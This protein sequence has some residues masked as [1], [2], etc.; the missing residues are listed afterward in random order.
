ME[1]GRLAAGEHALNAEPDDLMRLGAGRLASVIT[2]GLVEL[3][4]AVDTT[5]GE[6][7]TLTRGEHALCPFEILLD[8]ARADGCVE[9]LLTACA[10][11]GVTEL[12]LGAVVQRAQAQSGD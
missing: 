5:P 9:D 7:V 10:A 12:D 11:A 2:L 4:F 3:G 6:H 8:P 1:L